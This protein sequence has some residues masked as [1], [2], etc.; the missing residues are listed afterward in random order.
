ME[1]IIGID[2]LPRNEGV[3]TRR[4]LELRLI[5]LHDSTAKPWAVFEEVKG[6]KFY[7]FEEVR[8]TIEMLTDKMAGVKKNI[9]D[10][11]IVC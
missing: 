11:P 2:M 5:H 8:Q 1:S 4:P 3:C 6:K 9:V 10:K 7:N